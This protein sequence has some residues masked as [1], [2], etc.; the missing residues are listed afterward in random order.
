LDVEAVEAAA[1]AAADAVRGGGGPH[2]LELR[3]YRF[4]AHSMFDPELYRDKAEVE[5]WKERC[6]IATLDRRLRQRG[7]LDDAAIGRTEEAVK[8]G[9]DAAVAVAEQGPWEPVT[10][11]TDFV[12]SRVAR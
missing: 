12:Y 5:R 1:R 9:I 11:L 3:T 10:T 7:L 6:P 8:T 2:F 4:R